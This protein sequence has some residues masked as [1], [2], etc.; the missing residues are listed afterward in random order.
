MKKRNLVKV[1][2]AS[3]LLVC[4]LALA[5]CGDPDAIKTVELVE[6]SVPEVIYSDEV[7]KRLTEIQIEITKGNG[8]TEVINITK[9]MIDNLSALTKVGTHTVNILYQG[10]VTIG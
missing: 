7:S 6:T 1:F 2:F 4:T 8:D 10:G 9:N 5:S 3:F